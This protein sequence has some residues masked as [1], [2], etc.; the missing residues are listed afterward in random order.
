MN[1][2]LYMLIFL[3]SAAMPSAI[4][5]AAAHISASKVKAIPVRRAQTPDERFSEQKQL[6][7]LLMQSVNDLDPLSPSSEVVD[8]VL[9]GIG[10][11]DRSSAVHSNREY[12]GYCI[13][14][15]EVAM[16]DSNISSDPRFVPYLRTL[17][18][19]E[20]QTI[21]AARNWVTAQRN[22]NSAKFLELLEAFDNLINDYRKSLDT[23]R[24][25]IERGKLT[26]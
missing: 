23:P 15:A 5:Y 11:L 22:S 8:E 24:Q 6:S 21:L 4:G 16:Q 17:V 14:L 9:R 19:L 1:V 3:T 18:E 26:P 2:I 25:G 12:L 20:T 10:L 7:H 13:K